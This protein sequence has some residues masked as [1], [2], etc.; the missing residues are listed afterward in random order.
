MGLYYEALSPKNPQWTI[1]CYPR[2][3]MGA[4][5]LKHLG[6]LRIL[7]LKLQGLILE[8]GLALIVPT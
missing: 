3:P 5:L 4:S 6:Q 1:K 2:L 7:L 8:R